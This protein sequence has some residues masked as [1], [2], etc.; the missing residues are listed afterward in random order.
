MVTETA[1]IQSFLSSLAA[2]QPTPG[3]G[4]VAALTGALAAAMGQMVLNYSIGKKDLAAFEGELK[5][6][7]AELQ[8]AQATLIELMK[9]DQ[10]AYAEM[11]RVKK[12]PDSDPTKADLSRQALLAGIRVPQA[13]SATG[14]AVINLCD[15]VVNFVNPY[16][17][18]DLA[19]C[20]DL[21]MA[22]VRCGVYSVRIN[23]PEISD[24]AERAK[25]ESETSRVLTRAAETI[26]RVSPR[27][28]A[29]VSQA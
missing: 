16:L 14:A 7:L 20:A 22:T 29:R 28:W 26:Q 23:L 19:V 18:S 2:R 27:I 6:A 3:G 9:E 21:A 5:P 10:A 4:A 8:R 1:T 13:I 15:Q 11:V 24:P 12:L 17:L 25:I